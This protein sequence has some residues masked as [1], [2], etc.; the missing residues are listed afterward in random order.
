[1]KIHLRLAVASA[2]ST[3]P[4]KMVPSSSNI[5]DIDVVN[6][7]VDVDDATYVMDRGYGARTKM[8][9][10]LERN[11]KFLVRVRKTFKVETIKEHASHDPHVTRSADVFL[12]TRPEKLRLVEFTDHEGTFFRL[13]TNTKKG[14]RVVLD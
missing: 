9:G 7:L 6:H 11:I 14:N 13:L 2:N 8:G 4:E 1:M 12:K 3:F 5:S 10:W